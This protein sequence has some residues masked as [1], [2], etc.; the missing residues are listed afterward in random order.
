MVSCNFTYTLSVNQFTSRF[1][2]ST[3][4]C[5]RVDTFILLTNHNIS[6]IVLQRRFLYRNSDYIEYSYKHLPSLQ[7]FVCEF[8]ALKGEPYLS[9]KSTRSRWGLKAR[10]VSINIPDEV[11]GIDIIPHPDTGMKRECRRN[12]LNRTSIK[13]V[14][15]S[16]DGVSLHLLYF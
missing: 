12:T 16:L 6:L 7:T 4:V 14:W 9:G 10:A 8:Q 13:F 1:T 5:I 2:H 3:Y 11:S 15:H